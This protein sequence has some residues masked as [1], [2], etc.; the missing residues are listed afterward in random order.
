MRSRGADADTGADTDAD[1][2][3]A[4]A[5]APHAGNTWRVGP[6]VPHTVRH[7]GAPDRIRHART[8]TG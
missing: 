4:P 5:P 1:H 3:P 7:P 8:T 2:R 6:A